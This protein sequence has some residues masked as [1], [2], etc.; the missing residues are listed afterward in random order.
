[1]GERVH[2]AGMRL[3]VPGTLPIRLSVVAGNIRIH[4]LMAAV[5]RPGDTM[6]DVGANIGY[7]ALFAAS[8]VGAAGHVVAVEPAADNVAVLR[9]N[10][11]ANAVGNIEVHAVAAGQAA[12]VREFYLRGDVS[13]VNSF[14]RESVYA[15]VT[16]V[17][18]VPVTPLDDICHAA[19]RL[20]KIDVEGAE[21]DVLA[22]MPRLLRTP[23][24]TLLVE[25]HPRLQEAAGCAA[26]ALPLA[27]LG[28]G[29]LL[30]AASH[31]GVRP[32]AAVDVSVMAGQL[33]RSGRPVELVADG[34]ATA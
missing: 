10:I 17:V 28:D 14:Y 22:G 33:R 34:R 25:W 31:S 16:S 26:E 5:L 23:G 6:I 20:V 32:L 19:P 13:A 30:R 8:L 24:L 1:M 18:R 29:F 15:D 9:R 27:L 3:D 11:A 21:L 2:L 12:A 7:N 4:R